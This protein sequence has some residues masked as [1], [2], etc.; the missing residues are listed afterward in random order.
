MCKNGVM[1]IGY[2]QSF[3][4]CETKYMLTEK[5]A[6]DFL[7]AAEDILCSDRYTDYTI[8]NIY[9]DTDDYYFIKHSLDKP[10]YKEKL[11]LR[12]YGTA[13]D[14]SAVFLEIKKKYRGIVYKRRITIPHC[15][16]M[17][18][19]NHGIKPESLTGF[20]PNQI[21]SEIDHLFRKYSPS[22]KLFLAYDR[23]A[24]YM[25]DKP[26]VRIT[27]DTGIRSR[28]ERLSLK[29]NDSVEYLDTGTEN[30]RL[31]ELKFTEAVPLEITKILSEL[32]IYPVSFSKYGRIYT[33]II[34][35]QHR[36][37]ITV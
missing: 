31:M 32:K 12:C 16:A 34:Q 8:S 11:R 23:M 1:I 21:F 14:N 30:Y 20:T 2:I 28:Q 29:I 36:K 3:R 17:Q 7:S 4:R 26:D 9:L 13:D 15:E 5:Q 35:P 10:I 6:A 18:Y 25:K 33:D 22:P 19:I 24:Y 27:F 37:E